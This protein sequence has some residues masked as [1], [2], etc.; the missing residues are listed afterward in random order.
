MMREKL[1]I[2]PDEPLTDADFFG[3]PMPKNVWDNERFFNEQP[4]SD[5]AETWE[6]TKTG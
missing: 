5:T 2:E 1:G 3:L 4:Y 6:S